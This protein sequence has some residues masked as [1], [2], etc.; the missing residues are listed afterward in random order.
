MRQTPPMPPSKPRYTTPPLHFLPGSWDQMSDTK[1]SHWIVRP[2]R[3]ENIDQ[4]H[5]Q[6]IFLFPSVRI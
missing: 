1:A 3:D 5:I 2:A 4:A 6:F